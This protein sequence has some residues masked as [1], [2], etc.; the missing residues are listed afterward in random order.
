MMDEGKYKATITTAEL[1][2]SKSGKPQVYV[3]FETEEGDLISFYGGLEGAG[4]VKFTATQLKNAGLPDMDLDQLHTLVGNE[5]QIVV[6]HETWEES[7]GGD[8]QTRAKVKFINSLGGFYNPLP[9]AKKKSVAATFKAM[10]AQ[11]GIKSNAKAEDT[12]FDPEEFEGDD[13]NF[14]D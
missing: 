2:E 6:V 14:D 10:A 1:S 12:S 7:D 13:I 4:A 8:G 11:M 5:V 3:S 9:E